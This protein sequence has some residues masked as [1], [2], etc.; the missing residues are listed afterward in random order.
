MPWK[1]VIIALILQRNLFALNFGHDTY[2]PVSR[3]ST[4]IFLA[5]FKLTIAICDFCCTAVLQYCPS[6]CYGSCVGSMYIYKLTFHFPPSM[7]FVTMSMQYACILANMYIPAAMI[8]S[9]I[10]LMPDMHPVTAHC[11]H[12][13]IYAYCDPRC[14]V[15]RATA[16]MHLS[17]I[18][19]AVWV[20]YIYIYDFS[21]DL[22]GLL[23]LC[24][25]ISMLLFLLVFVKLSQ[26]GFI[27]TKT[28]SL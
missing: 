28:A 24:W 22:R 25:W 17:L 18:L 11:M 7:L 21:Y 2:F 13:Y 20:H 8:S 3:L 19:F 27:L 5:A 6:S 10:A 12:I 14:N 16:S 23:F 4:L 9:A 15:L 26:Y 1:L